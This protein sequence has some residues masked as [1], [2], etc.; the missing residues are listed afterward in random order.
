VVFP[1]QIHGAMVY[2]TLSSQET[3]L[4][5]SMSVNQ[6]TTN[7]AT[8]NSQLMLH[9]AM[10]LIEKWSDIIMPL[11][12]VS[13]KS[14]DTVRLSLDGPTWDGIITHDSQCWVASRF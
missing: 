4:L 8:A 14:G 11:T 10:E 6:D 9:S 5:S 7:C 3:D 12:E 2:A 13:M 1:W